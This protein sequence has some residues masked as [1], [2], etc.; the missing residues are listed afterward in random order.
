LWDE[1]NCRPEEEEEREMGTNYIIRSFIHCTQSS[2]KRSTSFI[3]AVLA[4]FAAYVACMGEIRN[5]Y[6]ILVVK[7]EAKQSHGR[8]TN[9]GRDNINMSL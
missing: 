7:H 8:P 1:L 6:N 2:S 4:G 5:S 9:K 3:R